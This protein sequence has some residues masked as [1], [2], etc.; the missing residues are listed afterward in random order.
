M[1]IKF[2]VLNVLIQP[3]FME[4]EIVYVKVDILIMVL[5]PNVRNVN[6]LV[7]NVKVLVFVKPVFPLL[8]ELIRPTVNVQMVIMMI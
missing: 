4:K 6:T 5:I 1:K 3:D 8:I 2:P 7:W